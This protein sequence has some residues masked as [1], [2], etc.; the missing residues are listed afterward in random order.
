MTDFNAIAVAS[1]VVHEHYPHVRVL[2]IDWDEQHSSGTQ[3]IFYSD[4]NVLHISI[5]RTSTASG[6]TDE[7]RP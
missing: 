7:V 6:K 2:I 5:H 4:P 1:K 3:N